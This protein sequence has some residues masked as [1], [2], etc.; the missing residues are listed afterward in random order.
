MVAEASGST[1]ANRIWGGW[2]RLRSAYFRAIVA[3][4]LAIVLASFFRE[5]GQ[6][7]WNISFW[8]FLVPLCVTLWRTQLGFL[9][10]AFLL[11]VSVSLNMQL[12]AVVGAIAGKFL[13]A[14]AYPG[15]DSAL[16]FLAAWALKGRMQGV[17]RVLDRFPSGVLLL[18]HAWVAL[19]AMVAVGRN[20]WQSASELSLRGLAYNVWLTRGIMWHDDYYPL[21]DSFFYSVALVMLFATWT[22]LH[23]Y[24]DW[25]LKRLIGVV[26][27]GAVTNVTFGL[28]QMA[29]NKGWWGQLPFYMNAFWQDLH[30]FGVFMA[31]SLI[32]GYGVLAT[33][34]TTPMVK[35]TVGLA[36]LAAAVGLYLSGSRST[37][38]LAVALLIGWAI[39]VTPKLRG[40]QRAIPALAMIAAL[41][42]IHLALDHGYRGIS[43]ASLNERLAIM[44]LK[45]LNELLSYRP[46]VWAAAL[47]M[48][49]AFPLFGL[50]QGAF[51]RLSA[52][53]AFSGSE[54]LVELGGDGVHNYP[55]RILVELGPVG[56][57]LLVLSAVPFLMLGRQ[58]FKFVSFYALVG[59]AVG[60]LYT[61][62]LLVR[63]LLMLCAVFAGSYLWEVDP[64]GAHGRGCHRLGVRDSL[65]PPS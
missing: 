18:F 55:F 53:P 49:G 12:N 26:L 13:H 40:W 3:L 16:G 65:R 15:V 59:L 31:G 7:L 14:W 5:R 30:S 33:R 46:E 45:S 29:T 1:D 2:S 64:P 50:G 6:L 63:E 37:L 32:L 22:L 28:W 57:G 43:Y 35:A 23:K 61:N 51:Y 41:G 44:D 48:Y 9:S 27:A 58:N 60:N 47:R 24:G 19:S 4:T 62:A 11:T 25:L 42:A 10:A 34:P 20:L 52:N 36:M 56:F 39:W 21:Q 54:L 8:L 38:L 17:E